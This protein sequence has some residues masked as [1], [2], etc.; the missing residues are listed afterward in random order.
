MNNSPTQRSIVFG[1]SLA[2]VL[3]VAILVF[4]GGRKPA[5]VPVSAPAGEAALPMLDGVNKP[6]QTQTRQ[7]PEET[8]AKSDS[9][10][11]SGAPLNH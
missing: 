5:P 11:A 3:V 7:T 6:E 2:T 4:T 8:P 9:K 10:P 1:A